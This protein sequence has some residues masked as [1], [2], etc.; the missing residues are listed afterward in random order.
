MHT[1]YRLS[2]LTLALA[3]AIAVP[4]QTRSTAKKPI[5][6]AGV[7][8][9]EERANL[10]SGNSLWLKGG[11]AEAAFPLHGSIGLALNVTGEHAGNINAANTGLS[12]VTFVAGPRYTVSLRRSRI[13][14][15]ALFGGLHAFDGTFPATSGATSSANAL[16]LQVGGGYDIDYK[17]HLALRLIDASWVRSRIPNSTTDTQNDLRLSAGVV[18]RFPVY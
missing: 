14:G 9:V 12:K 2:I 1:T 4:A 11:S 6:D 17:K 15:E 10:V 3:S 16:A 7:F 13:F 5:F 18:F 8:F